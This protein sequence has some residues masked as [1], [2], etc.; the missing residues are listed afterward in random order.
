VNQCFVIMANVV[1]AYLLWA[2][3]GWLGIHHFYLGRDKQAF[4]WW[5]LPGGY[6]GLGWIRDIWRIPEYV[7]EANKEAGWLHVQEEKMR[8]EEQPPWKMARWAG[9]LLVGNMFGMLPSMAVP[10][11]DEL[12]GWDLNVVGKLLTPLGCALGVWLVGNIGRWEGNLKRPLLGCY[13]T[14]P[15]YL[16]GMNV[17]SWTTIL[18][19]YMFSRKWRVIPS[20]ENKWPVWKRLL[21]LVLCGALYGGM[22]S[23]YLYHNAEVVHNGDRI[24]LREAVGNFVN[25]PAVQEFWRNLKTLWA[26]MQANG[27]WSTWS[28]LVESLDPFGEKNA[29]KVLGLQKGATQEEIR[30]KYKEL[31]KIH[32]PDKVKGEQADKD[33]AEEKFVAIQQAYEKLSHLKKSRA[34]ANKK[35]ET[36][37]KY[38]GD[39]VKIE[40]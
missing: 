13:L 19:A 24:K 39:N 32:H 12:G 1:V 15:A 31:T 14:L 11:Q 21:V 5:C 36:L 34:K 25:S 6:F 33:A 10:G 16:Y 4:I 22:W 18:G 23:S 35:S 8:T 30:S 9:M 3:G 20:S 40:L 17:V 37:H 7:R 27:F 38:D 28:Q 26:H 2:V 29:L